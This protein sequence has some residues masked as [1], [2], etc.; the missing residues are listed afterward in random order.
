MEARNK[1]SEEYLQIAAFYP[2]ENNGKA[3]LTGDYL[4]GRVFL[5][6]PT[7]ESRK[8]ILTFNRIQCVDDTDYIWSILYDT[9]NIIQPEYTNSTSITVTSK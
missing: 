9:N 3:V 7:S 6:Y 1:S 2:S 4:T 5:T 8:A